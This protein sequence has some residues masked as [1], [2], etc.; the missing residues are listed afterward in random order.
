M[1]AHHSGAFKNEQT[2][3]A[4]VVKKCID[5][6]E[7]KLLDSFRKYK[8]SKDGRQARCKKCQKIIDEI[9]RKKNY[10]KITS[11]WRRHYDK[12]KEKIKKR[13]SDWERENKEYVRIR[14]K[15]YR[16]KNSDKIKKSLK[17]YGKNNREKLNKYLVSY[18]KERSKIDPDFEVSISMQRI[19]HR[20]IRQTTSMKDKRTHEILGYTAKDLRKHLE[21]KFLPGMS[22]KNRSEWHIDHI[23]PVSAFITDGI[24]DPAIINALDNLQPLW[25]ED[26]MRKGANY[27][28]A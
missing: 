21:S 22:W 26:N 3:G 19:L 13:A 17:I 10:E 1:K 16:H 23:K 12:N 15:K 2:I 20:V 7:I 11:N 25:A 4:I 28:E 24:N 14:R 8:R 5:C 27:I 18:R 9:W 6:G